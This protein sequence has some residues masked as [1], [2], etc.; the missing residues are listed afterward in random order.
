MYYYFL[1]I[2]NYLFENQRLTINGMYRDLKLRIDFW[3][4]SWFY[5]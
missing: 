4:V 1:E 2:T 5:G 3:F